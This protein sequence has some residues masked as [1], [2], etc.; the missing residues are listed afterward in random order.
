M[1]EYYYYIDGNHT[2]V[3]DGSYSVEELYREDPVWKKAGEWY[4]REIY[5]GQGFDCLWHIS[6][7][8]AREY[9][10]GWGLDPELAQAFPAP[11][12]SR[13]T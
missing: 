5:L 9:L 11:C 2:L 7:E 13:T 3:R 1:R 8:E 6:L 4:W 10:T 12:D